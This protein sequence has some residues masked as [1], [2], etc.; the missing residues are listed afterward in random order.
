MVR[1]SVIAVVVIGFVATLRAED[2]PKPSYDSLVAEAKKGNA[3]V[4]FA[5][6][7]IAFSETPAFNPIVIDETTNQMNAAYATMEY[8]AA[9]AAAEKVLAKKY[10]DLSA[11][12]IAADSYGELEK[13][14]KA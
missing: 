3:K 2:P 8:E 6:M 5:R 10:V 13:G 1:M 12:K 9:V 14:E 11:H 4:D 7:R